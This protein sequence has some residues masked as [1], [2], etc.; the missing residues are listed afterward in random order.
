MKYNIPGFILL[1][2]VMV[3]AF[4]CRHHDDVNVKDTESP[5]AFPAG[6]GYDAAMERYRKEVNGKHRLP[7]SEERLLSDCR[8]SDTL[9]NGFAM[10]ILDGFGEESDADMDSMALFHGFEK[11]LP[12]EDSVARG[13]MM[14]EQARW[15]LRRGNQVEAKTAYARSVALAPD[16]VRN[17]GGRQICL[18]IDAYDGQT[19]GAE[20]YADS[21][22]NRMSSL[23][24]REMEDVISML[25]TMGDNERVI[26]FQDSLINSL[27]EVGKELRDHHPAVGDSD[28]FLRA[29]KAEKMARQRQRALVYCI[30]LIF[31][32]STAF[33]V[34]LLWFRRKQRKADMEKNMLQIAE[35]EEN[36]RRISAESESARRLFDKNF[37]RQITVLGELVE[38]YY[39]ADYCPAQN[40]S[41]LKSFKTRIAVLRRPASFK[42]I[43]ESVDKLERN[44]VSRLKEQ[45]P[46]LKEMDV[47]I[48]SLLAASL[49]TRSICV[50]LDI[51][52]TNLYARKS[53]MAA[54]IRD[55]SPK[56]EGR[57]LKVISR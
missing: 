14:L 57:F 34:G 25:R 27:T 39:D 20:G 42:L 7:S 54:K 38:R 26:I 21:I 13:A 50:L 18:W 55:A 49:S 16:F 19:D 2:C 11:V 46:G 40:D 17:H 43:E 8:V 51:T 1:V 36:V 22:L 28:L 5:Q 45:M 48:F 37:K 23:T 35:L 30:V 33:L 52:P 32:L 9:Q 44:V 31:C 56:D 29:A 3:S 47:R 10:L 4:A 15:H 6:A 41:I 12:K 53:R 24:R